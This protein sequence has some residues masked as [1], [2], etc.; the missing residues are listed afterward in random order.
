MKC[1]KC[2]CR[3][4]IAENGGYKCAECRRIVMTAPVLSSG[5]DCTKTA[6]SVQFT[7]RN[8]IGRHFMLLAERGD[9][10]K[11]TVDC[12][13]TMP[14]EY[15]RKMT[16]GEWNR[17]MEKLFCKAYLHEW[18][19]GPQPL[20]ENSWDITVNFEFDGKKEVFSRCGNSDFPPYWKEFMSAMR[21]LFKEAGL[22][23]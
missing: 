6:V 10:Y 11:L 3:E 15:I 16:A 8:I 18:D 17:L 7:F 20:A 21:P 19:N 23:F 5:A 4:I 22:K 13:Q 14:E 9:T 2:G 12:P 1:S